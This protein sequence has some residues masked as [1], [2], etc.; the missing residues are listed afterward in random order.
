MLLVNIHK[1]VAQ[2][3]HSWLVSRASCIALCLTIYYKAAAFR[4]E[5]QHPN[6]LKTDKPKPGAQILGK[7]LCSR[8]AIDVS[9]TQIGWV[10]Y[11]AQPY[12]PRYMQI[13]QNSWKNETPDALFGR[14][15][16]A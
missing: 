8:K 14:G 11:D 7:K 10:Q 1:N 2:H 9:M 5:F 12:A 13:R 16:F 15:R 4:K 6:E 3:H